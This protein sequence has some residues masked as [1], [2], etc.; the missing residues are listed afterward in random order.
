MSES[1]SRR[2]RLIERSDRS[3]LRR[4]ASRGGAISIAS[5]GARFAL[6]I[7]STAAL[8]RLLNPEQFGIFA[9]ATAFTMILAKFRDAG[10]RMA[11]VQANTLTHGQAT[12]LLLINCGLGLGLGLLTA[13]LGPALVAA[14]GEPRLL[15]VMVVL[16]IS[17]F[18]GSIGV[19]SNGIL[20][21][22]MR[23]GMLAGIE[24]AALLISITAGIVA[25][26][27]GAGVLSLAIMHL[28]LNT[29]KSIGSIVLARWMPS[30]PAP[31]SQVLPMLRFGITLALAGAANQLGANADRALLG[32]FNTAATGLYNKALNLATLPLERVAPAFAEVALPA[33]SGAADEPSRYA[34]TYDRL[35]TGLTLISTPI[36]CVLLLEADFIVLLVLG[37]QWSGA[38]PIF[39]WFCV[40]SILLPLW[41]STGWLFVSQ[42]RGGEMLRWQAIDALAKILA[43][44]IAV[45]WGAVGL[46]IAFSLRYVFLIP[47]LYAMV[48]RRGPVGQRFLYRHTA[49]VLLLALPGLAIAGGV[50]FA[51]GWFQG[52]YI[53]GVGSAIY[54]VV[55]GL[56]VLL[57][58]KLR[59][60]LV[61]IVESFVPRLIE[62]KRRA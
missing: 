45:W 57:Q 20:H 27:L 23:L 10:L 18:V 61:Y 11:N 62:K 5:Q 59:S 55:F 8:A 6:G 33:L 46:A 51:A 34:R 56:T 41:N 7:G 17:F 43:A 15:P 40:G 35:I 37:D 25:A 4:D 44:A 31:M 1:T 14:Y 24:L 48:G 32:F 28:A 12:G 52:G 13:A 39:R 49:I 19:Q 9:I 2:D 16:G 26:L 22:G 42:G 3:T 60:Q 36:A 21:R 50:L 29:S 47:A 58:P 54:G 53:P 38:I 30:R